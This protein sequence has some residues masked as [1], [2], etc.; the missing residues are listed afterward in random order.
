MGLAALGRSTTSA[1]KVAALI[2]GLWGNG[3]RMAT[4]VMGTYRV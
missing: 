2:L 1:E 3:Y 4:R